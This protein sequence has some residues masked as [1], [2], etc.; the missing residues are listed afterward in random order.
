MTAVA[1]VSFTAPPGE[2]VHQL[3]VL[4]LDEPAIGVAPRVR[5]PDLVRAHARAGAG[6]LCDR[7]ASSTTATASTG[8]PS[9]SSG[10]S[11]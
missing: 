10:W 4:L 8:A 3:Q 9:P 2:I 1:G 5:L 7:L 6:V 11:G